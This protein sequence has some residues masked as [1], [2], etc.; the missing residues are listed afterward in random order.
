MPESDVSVR[1]SV[2]ATDPPLGRFRALGVTRTS[3]HGT[4]VYAA[5]PPE[6][7]LCVFEFPEVLH[8]EGPGEMDPYS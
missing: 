6:M 5:I 2:K 7:M 8:I 3:A 1:L 4:V